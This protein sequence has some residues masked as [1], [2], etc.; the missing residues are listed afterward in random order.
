MWLEQFASVRKLLQYKVSCFDQHENFIVG[1]CKCSNSSEVQKVTKGAVPNF[2]SLPLRH[3]NLHRCF[4]AAS[5]LPCSFY[6]SVAFK[7][8]IL[9]AHSTPVMCTFKIQML[10]ICILAAI[11]SVT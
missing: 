7:I 10:S 4:H 9:S 8:A 1:A 6:L 5:Y 11:R 3:F 2:G